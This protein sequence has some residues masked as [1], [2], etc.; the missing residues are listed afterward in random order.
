MAEIVI[1]PKQGLQM[2]EGTII[3]WLKKVGDEVSEGEPLF[4]METDKLTITID[5]PFS[6]KLLKI[7]REEGETV[8]ITEPI[9]VIGSEGED[10]SGIVTGATGENEPQKTSGEA[11]GPRTDEESSFNIVIMPKQGLQM[12]EGTII[13][14]LK[15]VGDD[16]S[17]G[18]PLF[19]METDKLTITID[20]PFA[21][22]LLK[23][24]REEG[25][26]VPITEPIAVIGKRGAD[27]GT[28]GAGASV[29]VPEAAKDEIPLPAKQKETVKAEISAPV[30][31][32]TGRVFITPRAK[33][34]CAERGID[35]W[36]R[37]GGSGPDG[38]IIERDVL[39][40]VIPALTPAVI[41]A[42]AACAKITI[43]A[44][45]ADSEKYVDDVV[46][47]GHMI[48]LT[49]L[50]EKSSA[51]AAKKFE[52]FNDITVKSLAGTSVLNYSPEFKPEMKLLLSA[53][54]VNDGKLILAVSFREDEYDAETIASF[55]SSVAALLENPL[56]MLA[57]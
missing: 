39:S 29:S 42:P 1:M 55:I 11:Q 53:G 33:M 52:G 17:E 30:R 19:E 31:E 44:N 13:S 6:G 43:T 46:K 8:P 51:A 18:E 4:E 25:E 50:I 10:V 12:T 9:A 22:T 36:S 56:L 48:T 38:L 54:G 28:V 14:W 15:K 40:Y 37:I 27:V 16:V 35:D 45:V 57:I 20:S 3:S 47:S 5:S 7:I 26:T 49:D 34:R 23:I 2:T 32:K 24:I 21:G 41:P